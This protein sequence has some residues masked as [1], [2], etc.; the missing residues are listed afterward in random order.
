MLEKSMPKLLLADDVDAAR[1]I[2]RLYLQGLDLEVDEAADGARAVE[3]FC[4]GSYFLVLLDL[5]MPVLHGLDAVRAMRAEEARSGR[6]RTPVLALTAH[7]DAAHAE[8]CLEAGCDEVLVKP[9][10][11]T[12]LREAVTGRLPA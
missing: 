1:A 7:D 5:E 10:N 8:A 3:L 11:R 9:L 4:A 12:R 2:A 6:P